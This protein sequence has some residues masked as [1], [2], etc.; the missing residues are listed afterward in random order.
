MTPYEQDDIRS[1]LRRVY[2]PE[3]VS[4]WNIN[5]RVAETLLEKSAPRLV[6]APRLWI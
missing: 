5:E 2:S 6:T 1:I 3:I 4:R